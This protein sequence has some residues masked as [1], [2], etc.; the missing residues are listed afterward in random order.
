VS[1]FRDQSDVTP[2]LLKGNE[3]ILEA[4]IKAFQNAE[5]LTIEVDSQGDI[6]TAVCS[7]GDTIKSGWNDAQDL[8]IQSLVR[9]AGHML[10]PNTS[11]ITR[12]IQVSSLRMLS[13]A[14]EDL[15]SFDGGQ[16]SGTLQDRLDNR[17]LDQRAAASGAIFKLFSAMNM[18]IV[19]F[20][21][22]NEFLWLQTPRLRG[23]HV[24]GDNEYFHVPYFGRDAWL[25]QH[26][27]H[28]LQGAIAMDMKRVFDIGP[29]FRQEAKSDF[30]ARHMSEVCEA[31]AFQVS[32]VWS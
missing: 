31:D 25:C 8:T 11:A 4:R 30:S 2:C 12:R 28:A 23:S 22:T 3:V 1:D 6:W 16:L 24:A 7:P 21:T 10:E 18:L 15:P 20:F 14:A 27:Q 17:I 19:E 29:V 9:I 26:T 13:K 32:E 5:D